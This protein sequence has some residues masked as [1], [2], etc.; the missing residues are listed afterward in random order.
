MRFRTLSVNLSLLLFIGGTAISDV[1]AA[2]NSFLEE[3]ERGWF[4]YEVPTEPS[5]EDYSMSP[6]NSADGDMNREASSEGISPQSSAVSRNSEDVPEQKSGAD[7]LSAIM[8]KKG[9]A[10]LGEDNIDDV[11]SALPRSADGYIGSSSLG[12]ILPKTLEI[13]VD[14]PTSVNVERYFQLQRMT[15]NKSE[16]FAAAARSIVIE[17]PE[18]DEMGSVVKSLKQRETEERMQKESMDETL[19]ELSGTLTL[20]YVYNGSCPFCRQGVTEINSLADSGFTVV[21]ISL[22]GIILEDLHAVRNIHAPR[23]A[24]LY[25][26]KSVPVLLGFYRNDEAKDPVVIMSNGL[27]SLSEIRKRMVSLKK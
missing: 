6:E 25:G 22:D 13:A 18:L 4:W 9:Y 12:V 20:V 24:S 10:E 2:G 7:V 14:H 23:I 17:S 3:S 1:R 21:G 26:I 5:D 19:H 16:N 27:L 11:I 15:M 8:R